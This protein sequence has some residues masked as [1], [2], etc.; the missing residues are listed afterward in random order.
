MAAVMVLGV[1]QLR[2]IRT[3]ADIRMTVRAWLED[4]K[5]WGD[6]VRARHVS[7][8]DASAVT[9]MSYIFNSPSSLNRA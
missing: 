8:W 7:Q 6:Q 4:L 9:D 3:D 1:K 5:G 2:L